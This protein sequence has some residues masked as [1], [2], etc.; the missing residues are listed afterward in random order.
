MTVSP[1]DIE[2]R[3]AMREVFTELTLAHW[4]ADTDVAAAVGRSRG[5][6]IHRQRGRTPVRL[7]DIVRVY[8]AVPGLRAWSLD[9]I[10]T[11][12]TRHVRKAMKCRVA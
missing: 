1:D 12:A 3:E 10:Y 4:A 2:L 11:T 9:S 5:W 8:R 7:E 6:V